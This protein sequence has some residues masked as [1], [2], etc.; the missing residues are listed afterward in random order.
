MTDT[1]SMT[2]GEAEAYRRGK[3]EGFEAARER[4]VGMCAGRVGALFGPS[5]DPENAAQEHDGGRFIEAH[6]LMGRIRAME[7]PT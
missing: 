5:R 2:L 1:S 4:A 6:W 7:P 3:A